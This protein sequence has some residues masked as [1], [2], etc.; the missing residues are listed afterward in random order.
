MSQYNCQIQS[1]QSPSL[2]DGNVNPG[3]KGAAK[4]AAKT[5][6]ENLQPSKKVLKQTYSETDLVA[7][8]ASANNQAKSSRA[9]MSLDQN[10]K[11]VKKSKAPKKGISLDFI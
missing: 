7:L 3:V 11:I 10:H 5:N 6:T 4:A 1:K 9:D 8:R 2:T